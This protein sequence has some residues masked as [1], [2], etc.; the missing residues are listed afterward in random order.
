[1]TAGYYDM[2]RVMATLVENPLAL[3]DPSPAFAG[4]MVDTSRRILV[5]AANRTGKTRHAAAR[6][7]R[8]MLVTKDGRFRAVGV[9]YQQSVSVVSKYLNSFLPPSSLAPSCRYSVEN[10]WTHQLIVLANGATCE[11]RSQDQAPIAHAGSDLDGV[12]CDELP[13]SPVFTELVARV[14]SRQGWLWVTATPIGRPVK[15][16]REVVEGE[17]TAWVQHVAEMSPENCPWYTRD[18]VDA[19][20]EEAR[21]FPDSFEQR[22]KGA[23]E[24][25]TTERVFSGF[26]SVCLIKPDDVPPKGVHLGVGVDHGEG[27]GKQV[28]VLIAWN[29]TGMWALDECVNTKATTP[30]QDAKAIREMLLRNGYDVNQVDRWVGD[31][32]SA[33]K[34]SAGT[35]VNDLLAAALCREAGYGRLAIRIEV[36]VKGMGSVGFGEKLVNAGFLRGQIKVAPE[37]QTLVNSLRHYRG[38]AADEP[39]KHALDAFR[40]VAYA[41]LEALASSRQT[42][43]RYTLR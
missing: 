36:P 42:A 8:E 4:F 5:R 14:M 18:Q 15:E 13:P 39:L 21:L 38:G 27:A 33:G 24:G 30:A 2:S 17:Q 19:W 26:D 23:W 32:N 22:I 34:L 16:F 40:Y 31:V 29:G 28:A 41:P 3:F 1:M 37:C 35:K 12:W 43:Q 10:G 9:T 20:I 25:I 7:A 11:I 6:L